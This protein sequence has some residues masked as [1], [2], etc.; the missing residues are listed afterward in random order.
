MN[1]KNLKLSVLIFCTMLCISLFS[2]KSFAETPAYFIDGY[3]YF[4]NGIYLFEENTL[5]SIVAADGYTISLA[6]DGTFGNILSFESTNIPATI[7]CKDSSGNVSEAIEITENF[8]WYDPD[9]WG[10]AE[11]KNDILHFTRNDGTTSV[12]ITDE[13]VTWLKEEVNEQNVWFGLN[14]ST[15][16][17]SEG[18]LFW[19]RLL[20]Q[21]TT[22]DSW[23]TYYNMLDDS[24]KNNIEKDHLWMFEIGVT[25][26]DGTEYNSLNSTTNFYVQLDD[27]WDADELNAVYISEG[28]D[29]DVICSSG[30]LEPP[31]EPDMFV[32]LEINH[33]SPYA[34]YDIYTK[35]EADADNKNTPAIPDPE[36]SDPDDSSSLKSN[37][38]KTGD[39]STPNLW[40]TLL[41]FSIILL[42][43]NAK[44]KDI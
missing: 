12:L 36:P 1:K 14:N 10:D 41:F 4:S 44:K 30:E 22:S 35:E 18:S 39:S 23:I 13:N 9:D 7:Y 32:S 28:P 31:T 17:F 40:S 6:A 19:V 16:E 24:H 27:T 43:V 33:F 15:H 29:E 20:N 3:E 34:I 11:Y 42:L 26:P 2:A 25:S 37:V 38:P 8:R 5:A 21:E